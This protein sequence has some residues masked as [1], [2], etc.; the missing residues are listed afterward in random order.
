[1]IRFIFRR[2]F[3]EM[4]LSLFVIVTLVF[5]LVRL[6]PGGPFTSEKN[7]SPL[8]LEELNRNYGLDKPIYIQYVNYIGSILKGNLGPSYKYPG[9]NVSE[10]IADAFPTSFE[11]GCYA[12]LIAVVLGISAGATAAFYRKS[13]IDNLIMS[14]SMGGICIPSFVLAPLLVLIFSLFLRWLPVAGWSTP[15]DRILPSLTLGIIYMAYIARIMRGSMIEIL[16]MDFIKAARAK[17]LSDRKIILK[18]ALKGALIP[19]VSF[20]GPAAAGLVTGSFVI[21]TIFSIPGLGRLF[22][23]AS[24]NRDYTMI[25]G[26]V[27][28]YAF[29]IILFN[30]IVDII[31][32]YLDPRIRYK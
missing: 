18:H 29:I 7:I 5:F 15:L 30:S 20:L 21:E 22:V 4:P 10:L 14:I 17:G 28:F 16:S 25:S 6:A 26:T 9:K 11:L 2:L 12:L 3:I 19:V 23:T 24:F 1:M 32:A 27:I 31:L 13:W 8:V